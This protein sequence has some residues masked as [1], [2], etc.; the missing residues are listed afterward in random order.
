M[1]GFKETLAYFLCKF[2][3]CLNCLC[4]L[5][6]VKTINM[7]IQKLYGFAHIFIKPLICTYVYLFIY[8]FIC[9]VNIYLLLLFSRS[10]MSDSATSWTAAHQV[11]PSLSPGV[12]SVWLLCNPYVNLETTLP[13]VR[14][15]FSESSN[16][17]CNF[18]SGFFNPLGKHFML[19]FKITIRPLSSGVYF[20]KQWSVFFFLGLLVLN[21]KLG[22][23]VLFWFVFIKLECT[24]L[25]WT[26]FL[27]PLLHCW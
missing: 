5:L 3:W 17:S 10:V 27:I 14:W 21:Q 11:C 4:T 1:T 19:P 22:G 23:S 9:I 6:S 16:Y 15:D 2:L 26:L 20:F 12:C 8:L 24:S 25:S 18:G 13:D 7:Y